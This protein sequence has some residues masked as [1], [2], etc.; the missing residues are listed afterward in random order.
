MLDKV[1]NWDNE[2]VLTLQNPDY[3]MA[4]DKQEQTRKVKWYPMPEEAV[5]MTEVLAP[6]RSEFGNDPKK[7]VEAVGQNDKVAIPFYQD[8]VD[9]KYEDGESFSQLCNH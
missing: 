8:V 6:L 7:F 1:D 5:S 2:S 4:S 3:S 9:G